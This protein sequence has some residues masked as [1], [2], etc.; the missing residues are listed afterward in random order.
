MMTTEVPLSYE[1]INKMIFT[2]R[3]S[4]PHFEADDPSFKPSKPGGRFQ[5]IPCGCFLLTVCFRI[6]AEKQP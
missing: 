6:V 4:P 3:S 5:S 2:S 1:A